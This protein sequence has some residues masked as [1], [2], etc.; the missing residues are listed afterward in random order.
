MKYGDQTAPLVRLVVD[1]DGPSLMG[2]NWLHYIRLDRK[3]I[4]AVMK[5]PH[6][7]ETLTEKFSDLFKDELGKVNDLKVSHPLSASSVYNLSQL[8]ALPVKYTYIETATCKDPIP[9]KV[10]TSLRM[11]GLRLKVIIWSHTSTEN[12]AEGDCLLW[13]TRVI[14]PT[15]YGNLILQE[16]HRDYPQS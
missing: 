14:I 5:A 1:G 4:H 3:N 15:K 6:P 16:L 9:S 2:R 11:A 10:L 8:D 12:N 13:G 7:T